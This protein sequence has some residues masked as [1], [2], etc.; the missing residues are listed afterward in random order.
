MNTQGDTTVGFPE[1]YHWFVEGGWI[2]IIVSLGLL[3]L[4][5]TLFG[6]R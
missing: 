2:W 4:L 3:W 6:K 5:S 1:L